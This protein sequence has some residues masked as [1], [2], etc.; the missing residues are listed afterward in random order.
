M[1]LIDESE[2][3]ACLRYR[4]MS[5]KCEGGTRGYKQSFSIEAR[6]TPAS[7]EG[8]IKEEIYQ[9]IYGTLQTQDSCRCQYFH[10][11]DLVVGGYRITLPEEEETSLGNRNNP[12][13]LITSGQL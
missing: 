13:E 8:D 7:V 9:E 12:P 10:V 1:N 2:P 3:M 11:S 6:D 5:E 4:T